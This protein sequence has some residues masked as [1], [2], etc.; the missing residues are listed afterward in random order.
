MDLTSHVRRIRAIQHDQD[1]HCGDCIHR[2]HMENCG[3]CG[4]DVEWRYR[5]T[6]RDVLTPGECDG[7]F[8]NVPATEQ[9]SEECEDCH[10]ETCHG[11]ETWAM[12]GGS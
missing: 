11:C 9:T 8:E 2:G 1:A 7:M 5:E 6:M 3:G 4:P 12:N 10:D